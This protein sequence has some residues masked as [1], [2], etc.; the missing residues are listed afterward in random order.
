M[1]IYVCLYDVI[2]C[3]REFGK[4]TLLCVCMR[5]GIVV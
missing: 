2:A 5:V 3:V 1:L 4:S